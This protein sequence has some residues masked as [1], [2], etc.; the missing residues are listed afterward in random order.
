MAF[1]SVSTYGSANTDYQ[2]ALNKINYYQVMLLLIAVTIS[3]CLLVK[4][5][6]KGTI[7]SL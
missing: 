6:Y 2:W 3:S 5:I 4:G 1:S 7:I